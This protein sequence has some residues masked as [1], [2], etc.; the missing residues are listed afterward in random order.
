M[1][2]KGSVSWNKGKEGLSGKDNPQWTRVEL[3][4]RECGKKFFV[5]N[6]RRDTA[7][8]CSHKCSEIDRDEGKSTLYKRIRK[9]KEYKLWRTSVF[10]RD[11]YTCVW[12]GE[13]GY[14]QADHIKP[15][16]LFPELRF[17]I[18]NGRTLCIDCHKTTGTYGFSA[19]RNPA[20]ADET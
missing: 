12:C 13:T 6:Y 17:A 14:I 20:V 2:K 7:K 16:S 8:F 10:E 15:F 19:W 5:K 11:E 18:D 4:C 3:V 1:F 9:S